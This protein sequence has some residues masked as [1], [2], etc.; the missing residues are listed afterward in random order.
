MLAVGLSLV[1]ASPAL[2][3]ADCSVTATGIAF[4]SYDPLAGSADD[5][6][7]TITVT[8][9]YTGPGGADKVDYTVSLSPG[10]SGS[11]VQRRLSAGDG[12]VG[13]NLFRDAARAFVWG[14]GSVGTVVA[15]GSLT[16]TPGGPHRTRSVSHTIYA[17]IPELQ[18]AAPGD[19]SDAIVVTLTY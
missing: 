16:V 17:R 3:I 15:S 19:Y 18:D 7:G 9:V 11:F 8:C 4:G 12:Y 14:N 13:Y 10:G 5:S 2:A 1:P 6:S